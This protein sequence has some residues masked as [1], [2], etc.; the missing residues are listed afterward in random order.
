M[1]GREVIV[2]VAEAVEAVGVE[3]KEVEECLDRERSEVQ[4]L[5]RSKE[6]RTPA[7]ST[8]EVTM[9]SPVVLIYRRPTSHPNH[10]SV[11][12][13][14]CRNVHTNTPTMTRVPP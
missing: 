5:K 12:G 13:N 2:G 14:T 10:H 1:C 11:N 8:L 9:Y 7:G 6:R 3:E 4:R